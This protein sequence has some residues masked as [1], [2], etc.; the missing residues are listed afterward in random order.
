RRSR[1]KAAVVVLL[2]RLIVDTPQGVS[3]WKLRDYADAVTILTGRVVAP[4]VYDDPRTVDAKVRAWWAANRETITTDP[5]KM[6]AEEVG[7][8]VRGLTGKVRQSW[9]S[10]HDEREVARRAIWFLD[11]ALTERVNHRRYW[12]KE[13]L[14]PLMLPRLLALADDRKPFPYE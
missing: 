3:R 6:S 8:V 13:E 2:W 4:E 5:E 1:S 14:H 9:N 10:S 11:D 7:R 12:W